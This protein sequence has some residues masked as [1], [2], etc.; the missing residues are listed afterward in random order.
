MVR[1]ILADLVQQLQKK[2]QITLA[3]TFIDATFVEDKEGQ[4][5]SAPRNAEMALKSGNRGQCK[6]SYLPIH[7][8]GFTA[9]EC[10]H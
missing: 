4:T 2:R 5:N 6:S 7:C 8:K 10:A 3:E 9:S 1:D